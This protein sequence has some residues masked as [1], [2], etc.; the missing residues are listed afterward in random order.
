[1][2][3]DVGFGHGSIF[4]SEVEVVGRQA[5]LT[6]I[7]WDQP[8]RYCQDCGRWVAGET[9]DWHFCDKVA[10]STVADQ[11][12]TMRVDDP[13]RSDLTRVADALE[14]IADALERLVDLFTCQ[15]A[16][17]GVQQEGTE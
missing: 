2:S 11:G 8:C 9:G 10:S 4:G 7:I 15:R 6:G 16:A 13:A 14:R 1:M 5:E 17:E 3:T 12:Y